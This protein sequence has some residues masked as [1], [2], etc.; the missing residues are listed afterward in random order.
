MARM[1]GVGSAATA[2]N[3]LADVEERRVVFAVLDSFRYV[4]MSFLI[5]SSSTQS[6]QLRGPTLRLALYITLP[7]I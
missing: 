5:L 7:S 4:S 6:I 1:N 3:P 2:F